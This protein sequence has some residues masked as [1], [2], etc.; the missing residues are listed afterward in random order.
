[1]N[2]TS[3]VIYQEFCNL[4]INEFNGDYNFDSK[5]DKEENL[6]K[7]DEDL[8]ISSDGSEKLRSDFNTLKKILKKHYRI[9]KLTSI[10]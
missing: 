5:S 9:R 3:E 10:V 4:F 1:M 8:G 7:L 6:D 2:N